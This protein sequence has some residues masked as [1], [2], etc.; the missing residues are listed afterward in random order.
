MNIA[1]TISTIDYLPQAKI[2]G[3]SLLKYN[4]DYTFV[5]GLIDKENRIPESYD[6]SQF[7]VIELE[8]LNIPYL[9]KMNELY[10]FFELCCA[11]KPFFAEYIF[12]KFEA[13]KVFYFDS[14]ICIYASLET[15]ELLL[16]KNQMVLTTHCLTPLPD[17]DKNS[18]EQNFLNG[19]IYNGGFFGLSRKTF[20]SKES[21]LQWWKEK[22]R[23]HCR[24]DLCNGEFVDQLW[25][26][27]IPIYFEEVAILRHIGYNMAVWNLHERRLTLENE[28]YF[29]HGTKNEKTELIFF[30]FTGFQND[31][32]S[33]LSKYQNRFTMNYRADLTL[34]F[35]QYANK[36]KS[37]QCDE[38]RNVT[39]YYQDLIDLKRKQQSSKGNH[40]KS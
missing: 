29:V 28:T 24:V 3:N 38:L 40:P 7:Q 25:L 15:A 4:P 2:L 27:L 11:L 34:I 8:E 23:N 10:N 31:Q 17:D 35:E 20:L 5:I 21:P 19:G 33:L 16:D 32:P 30:H 1:Y 12:R 36:W 6:L 26:N 9:Q 13:P 39:N 37:E 18:K 14:D 22:L